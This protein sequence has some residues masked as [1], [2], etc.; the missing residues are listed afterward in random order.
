[1]NAPGFQNG[2]VTWEVEEEGKEKRSNGELAS[3]EEESI[4]NLLKTPDPCTLN[5]V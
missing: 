2:C 5:E 1:M 4:S 3:S